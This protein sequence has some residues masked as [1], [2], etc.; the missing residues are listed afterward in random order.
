MNLLHYSNTCSN[1]PSISKDTSLSLFEDT[2]I[3]K[4][5]EFFNPHSRRDSSFERQKEASSYKQQQLDAA[6]R[7][8]YH[9]CIYEIKVQ[10]EKK[11]YAFKYWKVMHNQL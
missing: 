10:H 11:K 7:L 4:F 6:H 1:Y 9:L 8:L 5:E 2:D 3:K